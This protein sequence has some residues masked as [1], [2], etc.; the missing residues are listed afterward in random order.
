VSTSSRYLAFV[1]YLLSLPGALVML[2]L[3]RDD[4]F[5]VYHSR[6]SLA[7]AVAALATP[8]V[9]AVV[10]WATA[11]IPVFGVVIGLSLFALVLATY[12]GLA[13]SWIVGMIFALRGTIRP[14]PLVG[15][16]AIRRAAKAAPEATPEE[17]SQPDLIERTSVTD[18]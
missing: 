8:L 2:L 15:S 6:Q 5:I 4:P 16:W 11:W 12:I 14:V 17:E 1:A 3:R 10:A 7:I 9:W 13:F 18:A